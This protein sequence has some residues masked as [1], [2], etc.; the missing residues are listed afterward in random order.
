MSLDRPSCLLPAQALYESRFGSMK[1]LGA[2]FVVFHAMGARV[3]RWWDAWSCGVLKYD[4]SR[5]QSIMRVATTASPVSG[6]EVRDKM[7]ELRRNTAGVLIARH[8]AKAFR[9]NE[10]RKR[11]AIALISALD[12]N[13]D[14]VLDAAKLI[15][16]ADTNND[17]LL[18]ATELA[19]AQACA[20]APKRRVAAPQ[21]VSVSKS[22][23]PS[24]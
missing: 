11:Q 12:A 21:R 6:S 24:G 5:T 4:M 18:D 23:N 19:R 16:R 15:A 3:A 22:K 13:N 2:F 14:G 17:G 7:L 10:Q 8:L 9:E 1:R 20:G